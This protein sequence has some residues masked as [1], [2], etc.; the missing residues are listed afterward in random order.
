MRRDAWVRSTGMTAAFV[1]LAGSSGTTR[2]Q[3]TQPSRETTTAATAPAAL[4]PPTTQ[5]VNELEEFLRKAKN[6]LPFFK[7]GADLR[8]RNEYLGNPGLNKDVNNSEELYQR[9]RARWWS[10]VTPFKDFDVNTRITWEGRNYCEPADSVQSGFR[11]GRNWIDERDDVLIDA[12]NVRYANAFGLPLTIIAGRQDITLGDAWF[13]GDFTPL[14]GART[15]YTDALRFTYDLRDIKTTVDAIYLENDAQ[16]DH[17]FPMI[18]QKDIPPLLT[19]QDERGVILY[20]INR[21]LPKTQVDGYFMYYQGKHELYTERR[22]NI[23]DRRSG[24]DADL[25]TFG[26]RVAGD[27]TDHWKYRTD[28]AAQFGSKRRPTDLERLSVCALAYNGRLSYFFNDPWKN[29]LFIDYEALSGDDPSTKTNEA[30]DIMWGRNQRWTELYGFAY[31]LESRFFDLGNIHRVAPGWSCRPTEKLQLDLRYQLLFA[32]ENTNG[33]QPGFSQTGCFRGQSI[34]GSVRYTFND[35]L[36]V[37]VL[38]ELVF[39]GDFYTD[40]RNDAAAFL[41]LEV[42]ITF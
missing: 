42:N 20:V 29:E 32:D 5:P 24:N 40:F 16:G 33:G 15:F 37:R 9:Y 18:C 11:V 35:H 38:P 12:L 31:S 27:I 34:F 2:A 36:F 10:T 26:F 4:L 1:I 8:L 3:T 23:Y 7:W 21:S 22:L 30:F 14:D 25:Y 41:R 28:L 13:T 19:E 39:P 17:W 6:P